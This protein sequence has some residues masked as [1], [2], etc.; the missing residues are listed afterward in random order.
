MTL[1]HDYGYYFS[2]ISS[3]IKERGNKKR[4]M[5]GKNRNQ[6]SCISAHSEIITYYCQL[7][8]QIAFDKNTTFR[9]IVHSLY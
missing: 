9:F 3:H 7:D 5:N 1:D 6:K 4:R 2:L 8:F